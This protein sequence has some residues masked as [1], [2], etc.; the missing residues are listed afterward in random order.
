M[1]TRIYDFNIDNCFD[2]IEHMLNVEAEY[3]DGSDPE[4]YNY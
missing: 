4:L 3:I 2:Q 1:E